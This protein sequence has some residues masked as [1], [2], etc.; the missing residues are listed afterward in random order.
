MDDSMAQPLSLNATAAP[1]L[2]GWQNAISWISAVSVAA[3]FLLAGIWKMTDPIEAGARLAQARVPGFLSEYGAVG[4]GVAETLSAILILIPRFRKLG[5]WL[6]GLMLL[7]F[8][9]WVGYFYNDLVGKECSCFPWIKRAVGPGFFIGDTVM[10]ALAVAAGWW[11]SQPLTWEW[12]KPAMLAAA[13]GVF[14]VASYGYA[15][16]K[17]AGTM[18]PPSV[19][20]ADGSQHDLRE[21]R[22]L[23]YFFDPQCMHCFHAAQQMAKLKFGETQVLALPTEVPQFAGGFL[24]DTGFRAKVTAA[25]EA[26][27]LKS[28]F[29]FG[30]PPYVVLLENGR[31]KAGIN[32]VDDAMPSAQLVEMGYATK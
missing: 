13:L 32:K 6:T 11:A 24:K 14:A 23:L 26:K 5:A 31:Q 29:P 17:T 7:A 3:L 25:E 4:F 21:G 27:R 8:M 20:L 19:L 1:P 28:I 9:I 18:A 22:Q 15:L 10:L 2:A 12:K 16:S 30:D